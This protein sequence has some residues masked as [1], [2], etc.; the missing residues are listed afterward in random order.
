MLGILSS[1][2]TGELLYQL[3]VFILFVVLMTFILR[4]LWNSVLTEYI[5]ILRPVKSLQDTFLLAIGIA[6]FRL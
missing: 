2:S 6:L 5:S 1:K 4:F 3:T